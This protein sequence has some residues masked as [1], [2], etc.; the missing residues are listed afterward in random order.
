IWADSPSAEPGGGGGC[1]PARVSGGLSTVWRRSNPCL[2]HA[3][4][5]TGMTRKRYELRY[6]R[7]SKCATSMKQEILATSARET[8]PVSQSLLA[9]WC[10]EQKGDE[11]RCSDERRGHLGAFWGLLRCSSV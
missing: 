2:P 7:K 1:P 3:H 8:S 6:E 4:H 5:N 10:R 9:C 11:E